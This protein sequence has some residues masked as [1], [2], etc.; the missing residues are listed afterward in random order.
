M[1]DSPR[2]PPRDSMRG[3]DSRYTER[4]LERDLDVPQG[5]LRDALYR[6]ENDE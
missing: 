6:D 3:T 2:H 4:D 1:S 5:L